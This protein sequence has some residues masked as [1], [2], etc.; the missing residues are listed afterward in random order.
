MKSIHEAVNHDYD[1]CDF[2]VTK[3]KNFKENVKSIH[4]GFKCNCELCDF[5]AATK[6]RLKN[7]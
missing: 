2:M 7:M 5:K 1:L 4:E 3:K 6:I